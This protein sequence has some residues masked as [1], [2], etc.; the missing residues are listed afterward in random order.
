LRVL[1]WVA[2]AAAL[3]G[4]V[5]CGGGGGGGGD[6]FTT[7]VSPTGNDGSGTGTFSAPFRSIKA[8]L[9]SVR[10][11][12]TNKVSI[13]PGSYSGA[14]GEIFP[15]QVPVNAVIEGRG[16]TASQVAIGGGAADATVI[17]FVASGARVRNLQA[18]SGYTGSSQARTVVF[19]AT[20]CTLENVNVLVTGGGGGVVPSGVEFDQQ[21]LTGTLT[22]CNLSATGSTAL[23]VNADVTVA[24]QN[25]A[26]ATCTDG[27]IVAGPGNAQSV[28]IRDSLFSGIPGT[29]VQV[30]KG[31]VNLGTSG[32]S[33]HNVFVSCGIDISDLRPSGTQM[34]AIDNTFT[35]NPPVCGVNV[36]TGPAGGWTW[37]VT[38]G[39]SGTC[40]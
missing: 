22:L 6:E 4:V 29:A 26:F 19:H 3:F 2:C 32:N 35:A 5:G 31:S 10:F 20:N 28:T 17:E 39:A 21:N 12:A 1:L 15:I 8:A 18:V 30:L 24:V 9:A 38:G 7:F 16:T 36:V 11:A 13:L 25:C 14:S 34:S 37:R 23:L 27:L 40:P 33:G